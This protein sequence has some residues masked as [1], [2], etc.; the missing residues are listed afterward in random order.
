[1]YQFWQN[2]VTF[3]RNPCIFVSQ[4]SFLIGE[5]QWRRVGRGEGC[6]RGEQNIFIYLVLCFT[7]QAPFIL[8]QNCIPIYLMMTV[9][10]KCILC[11]MQF[12]Y[13]WIQ[14]VIAKS[15]NHMKVGNYN[16]LMAD[17]PAYQK[18]ESFAVIFNILYLSAFFVPTKCWYPTEL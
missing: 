12:A 2:H 8:Y 17:C 1:M 13:Y 16:A 15:L 18:C 5:C 11:N 9:F 6:L 4:T 14:G 7:F 3:P 10:S